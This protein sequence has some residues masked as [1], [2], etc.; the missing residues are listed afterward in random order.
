[1]L[2]IAKL[3]TLRAVLRHASFSA[4]A[5]ELHVTQP[6]VSRQVAL[7]ERQLGTLLVR[8]TPQGVHATE[9]GRILAG[10]ADAVLARLD[11]AESEL[12][13]L[14]GLRR[15]T[16]RLGSFLSAL[17]HLSAEVGA[18][19]DAA[20]PGVELLDDLVDRAAALERVRRGALDL[21]LVFEHDFEP[22]PPVDGVE[23][24]P[25][26]DDPVRVVLPATHPLAGADA[27][28]V[29]DLAAD[30][31]VRP[32]EGSAAR[33]LDHVLARAGVRPPVLLAGRGDEP[34]EAQALVAAGR[35]VA[36]THDL[37]VVVGRHELAIRPLRPAAGVRRVQVAVAPGRRPPA[38]TAVLDA[39]RSVGEAHRRRLAGAHGQGVS[40]DPVP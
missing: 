26:F 15:G 39:V 13:E 34:F 14:A 6:A 36:L 38:V 16:V 9:A 1:M 33:R 31:W 40:H 23:L 21:A 35:G 30:T 24:H 2:D 11:L 8:R 10:H 18:L 17:V 29:A 32:H 4:A 3:A 28:A 22:A 27:V 25:L 12:R 19:L 5:Q 37:T 7:L 20:H